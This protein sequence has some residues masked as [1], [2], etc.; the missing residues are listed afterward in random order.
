MTPC[1]LCGSPAT[2]EVDDGTQPCGHLCDRCGED[3]T[4]DGA[5]DSD[6]GGGE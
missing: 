1:D 5:L 3:L 6:F 2:W 4:E